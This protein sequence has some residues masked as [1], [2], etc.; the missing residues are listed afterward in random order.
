MCAWMTRKSKWWH[1][2]RIPKNKFKFL[3]PNL[4]KGN[5]GKHGINGVISYVRDYSV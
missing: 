3:H 4:L 2:N 5:K 1:E